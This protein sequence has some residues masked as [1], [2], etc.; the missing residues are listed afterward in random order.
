MTGASAAPAEPTTAVL[1]EATLRLRLSAAD[2][3]YAGELVA[4]GR[5]LELFGDAAT[6]LSIRHD[7]NEGLLRA[8][9]EIEFLAPVRAGD[10]V[11]I[12]SRMVRL[13]RTSRTC[14]FEAFKVIES[15]GGDDLV[16]LD[17]PLL[18]ARATGT[19]VSAPQGEETH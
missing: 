18:V 15:R 9:S 19:V 13:G 6:E 3:H 5:I 17:E 12:R 2:A 10:F 7:G 14:E 8:Y 11:E 4:G 1:P 16:A